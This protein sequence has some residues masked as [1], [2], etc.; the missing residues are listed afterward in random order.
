[1]FSNS[2]HSPQL[3]SHFSQHGSKIFIFS[4][5]STQGQSCPTGPE[6]VQEQEEEVE[7]EAEAAAGAAGETDAAVGGARH[8]GQDSGGS[9]AGRTVYQRCHFSRFFRNLCKTWDLPVQCVILY[10]SVKSQSKI[11]Q[12][13]EVIVVSMVKSVFLLLYDILPCGAT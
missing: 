2:N 9:R 10:S 12:T 11:K 13:W 5:H 6:D 8:A 3:L 1:M 7:E 4:K